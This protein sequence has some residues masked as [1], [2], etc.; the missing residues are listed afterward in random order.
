MIAGPNRADTISG[1]QASV[2]AGSLVM[3]VA[4]R[5]LA[6]NSPPIYPVISWVLLLTHLF[7]RFFVQAMQSA[8]FRFPQTGTRA[9][10]QNRVFV[11]S[12][13]ACEPCRRTKAKCEVPDEGGPCFKCR[14]EQRECLF[15][16]ERSSKKRRKTG[17]ST[18]VSATQIN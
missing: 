3:A 11:R 5:S 18:R 6:P 1:V 7:H 8:E 9:H 10:H 12:Y 15:S 16:A 4:N 2:V 13:M 14:R 17:D